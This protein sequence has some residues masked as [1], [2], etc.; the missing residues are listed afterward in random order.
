MS[1]KTV[2]TITFMVGTIIILWYYEQIGINKELLL[3]LSTFKS[4]VARYIEQNTLFHIYIC[5]HL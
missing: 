1:Q 2:G 4:S 3:I 5:G